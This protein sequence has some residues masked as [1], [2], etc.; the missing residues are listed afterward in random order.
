M[1]L[2]RW[3]EETTHALWYHTLRDEA[4]LRHHFRQEVERNLRE[5]I[6]G[7]R[8][9]MD[10]QAQIGK[11]YLEAYREQAEAVERGFAELGTQI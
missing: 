2:Q 10:I 4:Y 7:Q 5:I 9:Q 3:W 1:A 11:A 8:A 6:R